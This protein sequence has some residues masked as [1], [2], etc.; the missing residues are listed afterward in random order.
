M[1]KLWPCVSY[2]CKYKFAFFVKSFFWDWIVLLRKR[3]HF[4]NIKNSFFGLYENIAVCLLCNKS[5]NLWPG[6]L[7]EYEFWKWRDID[8]LYFSPF[9][10]LS[11]TPAKL[12]YYCLSNHV[13]VTLTELCRINSESA[14]KM[15][16]N[17][18]SVAYVL[19]S[20]GLIMANQYTQ[21][22]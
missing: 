1:L 3:K 2:C 22:G 13:K 10:L 20:S 15:V 5:L 9:C 18:C 7:N 11:V 21:Y 8:I 16:I 6:K 4:M 17:S 12:F 14:M 19:P